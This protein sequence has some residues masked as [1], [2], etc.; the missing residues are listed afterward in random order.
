[1]A[2]G[3]IV[4]ANG[5]TV[6]VPRLPYTAAQSIMG[7]FLA[8]AITPGILRSFVQDWPVFLAVVF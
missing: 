7:L 6:R 5:G 2:A 4:G 8:S 3:V 1:M